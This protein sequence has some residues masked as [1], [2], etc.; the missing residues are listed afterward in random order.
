MAMLRRIR[1]LFTRGKVEREI[2]AELRAH[3]EMRTADNMA[4][5][6]TV[7]EARRDARMKFG[8]PVVMKEKTA[9]MDAALWV[10]NFWRD[11]RYAV[12][13]LLKNPA[14]SM[15][16]V[17]TIALGIGAN[18][19]MFSVIRA[20]LLKP[21]GYRNP[22]RL[23]LLST[24]AT[25]IRFE[26][27]MASARSYA[28]LGAYGM[29]EEFAF[30]G[31]G[32]P[33][34]LTGARVSGNFLDI[35]SVPPL[36]GRSFL[37]AEDK[38]GAPAVAMISAELWQ[39][40]F[41]R[42]PSVLGKQI[43][44]SGAPYTIIGVLPP[45]F[46]FPMVATDVW[47]TRPSE[48]SAMAPASQRISPILQIFGRL[49]PHVDMAAANAELAVID[50]QYAVA[51]PTMLDTNQ[52]VARISNQPPDHLV[53]MKD[54]LVSDIRSKLWLLFGAVG[55]VLLIVCANIASLLLARATARA[56]EFA[57]RAAIGAGRGRILGQL[58]IE[59]LVLASMGGVVGVVLAKWSLMGIRSMTALDLP[60]AGEIGMDGTVLGFAMILTLITGV[61]FGLWPALSASRPDLAGVLRG[62][63]EGAIAT[64]RKLPWL[65]F[66]ARGLLVVGQ[67]ALSTVLLIGAVL[68]ME[69]LARVYRVDPGFQVSNLLTMSL[70]P[71]PTRYDTEAKRAA[72]YNAVVEHIDRLPGVR[73][74]AVT[75]TVPM[76]G[77]AGVP[78]QVIGMP[79]KQL[80]E[81]PIAV[82]QNITPEYFQTM[83]IPLKRGREFMAHDDAT[84]VPV[85]IVDESMA[86][87]FW[88]QYPKGTD[89]IGQHILVGAH[90]KPTEIVGIVADIRQQGLDT[91]PRPG[92]YL[93]AAQR[94]PES[95]ML[96][97]RTAGDPMLLANAVRNQILTVDR[98]QPVSDVASMRT[99][100]D[101]SEGQLR[102]M[103]LLLGIFAGAATMIA[104]VG[105]YGVI[106]HWV[107]QRT[108]ELGIRRA[109][110][111]Q[112]SNILAL[113]MGQGLRLVVG[114]VLLGIC[115]AFAVTR[116]LQGLLFH[117]RA[118]DPA[119]Y[120]GVA[121]LFVVVAL[122]AS[123]FPARRAA[124]VDPMQALRSE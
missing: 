28:G 10:E 92:I 41:D 101:A 58:L 33:E 64:G 97:V 39:R 20:V 57:V 42:S 98:E 25:P 35:L 102:D 85:A 66:S 88:P 44:L 79:E 61:L 86:R 13:Q 24:G 9:A 38:P 16:V 87:R 23:V 21:L 81:R 19:A 78:V 74:A 75:R 6:M 62:S 68:L 22:D 90:S 56:K 94:P 40:R 93:A 46:T 124:S 26:A 30:S 70:A 1:N 55:L 91:E 48:W 120:A 113:V 60:R 51:H 80:N 47:V 67:V 84:S 36:L 12:R 122:A 72:F 108:K 95:A 34:V 77:W 104:V 115:G 103:M 43:T 54:Q 3:I 73:G 53:R 117:V 69:S 99:V 100:V 118:T 71:S 15:A 65:R 8:N 14:F 5:G 116:V 112:R 37:P 59:S 4:R 89:P 105:L 110:G 49:K 50:H 27:M 29:T 119:T 11:V 123:Y 111:A 109:L 121:C 45:K 106:A 96:A 76:D 17:L 32:Q 82:L 114:G 2:D 18:T 107:A 63:G 83:K 7:E 52:S 31:D